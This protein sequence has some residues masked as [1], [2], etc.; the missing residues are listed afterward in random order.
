MPTAR[1][2][3]GSAVVGDAIFAIGGRPQTFGP[4]TFVSPFATVER[5]DI[6]ANTWTT[7]APLPTARSDVGAIAHGGKVYVFGGCTG[8]GSGT[9]SSE[10]DIYNPTTNTWTTGAPMPTAR[11]GFYG[12]GIDGD[13]IYVMGGENSTG[14]PSPANEVYDVA[15]NSWST[16]TPMPHPRGEMGVDEL[17]RPGSLADG[18]GAALG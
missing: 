12:I 8:F 11:A 5:Y 13:R 4:C 16:D 6:A 17:H 9:V 2:G 18:R 3:L 15:T 10:V 1:D 7:V 14:A